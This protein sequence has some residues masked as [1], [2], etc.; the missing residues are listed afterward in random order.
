MTGGIQLNGA[1]AKGIKSIHQESIMQLAMHKVHDT[2]ANTYTQLQFSW[3]EKLKYND[4]FGVTTY[5]KT[6]VPD[7]GI[8][9]LVYHDHQ[10]MLCIGEVKQQGSIKKNPDGTPKLGKRGKNKGK[11]LEAQGNASQDRIVAHYGLYKRAQLLKGFTILPFISFFQGSS[12][13]YHGV[14]DVLEGNMH[15][16]KVNTINTLYGEPS[17]FLQVNSWTIDQMYVHMLAVATASINYYVER[18]GINL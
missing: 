13:N 15:P 9:W 2:V 16:Y 12:S 5:K 17:H 4:V 7:G 1:P 3:S 8:L 10:Y 11:P 14:R 18:L 6:D